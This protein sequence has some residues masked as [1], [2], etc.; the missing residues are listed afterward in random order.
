M[1]NAGEL[2]LLVG[3]W[4]PMALQSLPCRSGTVRGPGSNFVI[5]ACVQL[6]AKDGVN[7]VF[8]RVRELDNPCAVPP[9]HDVRH[10]LSC[11]RRRLAC[12]EV[13]RERETSDG[14]A[15][16]EEAGEPGW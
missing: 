10:L 9:A 11:L 6:V 1:L 2:G 15:G 13:R 3:R 8:E 14:F 7:D 4:L 12:R 5:T 16:E